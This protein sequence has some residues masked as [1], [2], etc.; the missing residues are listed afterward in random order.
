MSI[1]GQY[2]ELQAAVADVGQ[3]FLGMDIGSETFR[4]FTCREI[5]TLATMLDA[6]ACFDATD[7]IRAW[8]AEGDDEGDLHYG[9]CPECGSRDLTWFSGRPWVHV[10][11]NG[12]NS[13]ECSKCKEPFSIGGDY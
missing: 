11:L 1:E 9:V 6:A 13:G 8:H 12:E 5:E 2:V 7:A 4:E 3:V 10:A